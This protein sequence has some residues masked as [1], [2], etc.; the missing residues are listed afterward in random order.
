MSDPSVPPPSPRK[1][2]LPL[3]LGLV[4][5]AFL[6]CCGGGTAI[7]LAARGDDKPVAARVAS[8]AG[9]ATTPSSTPVSTAPTTPP[10]TTTAPATTAPA[11]EPAAE[12]TTTAP[13]ATKAVPA[14]VVFT[15][16]GDKVIRLKK[17]SAG[18]A[19]YA[20]ISHR[21]SSNFAVWT[22]GSDGDQLDLLVNEI[23]SYQGSRPVDF[24]E[25]P[26]ALKVEAD[27]SWK[28]VV[29]ALEKAPVWPSKT[30]GQGAAVLLVRPG[31][32]DGLATA[33]VTHKGRSNFVVHSYG[34]SAD[35]LVNEI[36]KYSGEVLLPDGTVAIV[37]DA[38]GSWTMKPS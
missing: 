7:V 25:T 26:A 10:P 22:I 20:V 18:H 8:S 30:S 15:G 12:P 2:R 32:I 13:T 6:L 34:D 24:D 28:I 1:N 5:G 35:L 11:T 29:K 3:I 38:D 37:I 36:G 17:L 14:D 27:G 31:A 21:G 33:K 16:R 9:P 23:G 4:V 19:H